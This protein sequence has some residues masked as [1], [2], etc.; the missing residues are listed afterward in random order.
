[1]NK[2][3]IAI[4][5]IVLLI[6]SLG[7]G[8]RNIQ[9][10]GDITVLKQTNSQN[11][12]RIEALEQHSR[13]LI[14]KTNKMSRELTYTKAALNESYADYNRLLGNY[15]R[16]QIIYQ[17]PASKDPISIWNIKQ[18]ID[19]DQTTYWTLL[20][21]FVNHIQIRTNQT[22]RF[23]IIDLQNFA[24]MKAGNP[25]VAILNQTGTELITEQHISQGCASYV[26]IIINNSNS[27][28]QIMPNVTATYAPTPFLTGHCSAG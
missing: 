12:E 20:D 23:E 22:V 4:L 1:L 27:T 16:D 10:V 6:F 21:T 13:D 25:Y 2:T 8:V 18:N 15:S 28:V 17:Y 11:T 9:L 26:L 7:F 24:N 3:A 5:I 14:N 19:P